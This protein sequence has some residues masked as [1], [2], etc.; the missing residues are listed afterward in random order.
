MSNKELASMRSVLPLALAV[1]AVLAPP[2]ANAQSDSGHTV[3]SAANTGVYSKLS[4]NEAR[5]AATR[6]DKA[7]IAAAIAKTN[8]LMARASPPARAW[9]R[10]EA[11][12]QQARGEP[13]GSAVAAAARERF[14][15]SL[16]DMDIDQIVQ[17]VMMEISREAER[18]LH[19]ELVQMQANLREKRAQR[20]EAQK[21]REIQAAT[22]AST[23]A[24]FKPA[25]PRVAR[26]DLA[27]YV[28]RSSDGRDNLDD[29]SEEQQLKMEMVM[30]RMQKALVAMSNLAKKESDTEKSIIGNLK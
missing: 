14:G 7:Q 20:E 16:S 17:M 25:Q 15:S 24:E 4:A 10:E 11:Q 8:A 28:A 23:H 21:M 5:M 29:M 6:Q 9:V 2:S 3:Q 30:D 19:D 26:A 22:R 1:A 18:E 13:S 27:A 12:R